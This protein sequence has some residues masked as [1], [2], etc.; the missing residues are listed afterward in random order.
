MTTKFTPDE[1]V[2]LIPREKLQACMDVL[3][4][5]SA[6]A[7]A[8]ITSDGEGSSDPLLAA[9]CR[10]RDE[11]KYRRD[12]EITGKVIEPDPTKEYYRPASPSN[13]F[14]YATSK[15]WSVGPVRPDS[16]EQ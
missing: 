7:R 9:C 2:A 14:G 12:D 10:I 4:T 15:G 5:L 13:G 11:I 6:A 16:N 1:K 8:R 3:A